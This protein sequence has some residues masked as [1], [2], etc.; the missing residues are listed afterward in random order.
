MW[1]LFG[2]GHWLRVLLVI[3]LDDVKGSMAF[4]K[5][6]C[7]L[8]IG[9]R[10]ANFRSAGA[11][12]PGLLAE[13]GRKVGFARFWSGWHFRASPMARECHLQNSAWRLIFLVSSSGGGLPGR[14]DLERDSRRSL[15][16]ELRTR[17]YTKLNFLT[18]EMPERVSWLR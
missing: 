14:L 4:A 2:C 15:F 18:R 10:A 1:M 8:S 11:G 6:Y 13:D 3:I 12:E 5:E 17:S 9:R 7:C 16:L